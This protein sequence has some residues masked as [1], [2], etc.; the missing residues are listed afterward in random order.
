MHIVYYKQRKRRKQ[1]IC[2]KRKKLKQ[3]DEKRDQSHKERE[4][5]TL[6]SA[7]K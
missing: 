2:S 7:E 3:K 1:A 4:Q 6:K 5:N